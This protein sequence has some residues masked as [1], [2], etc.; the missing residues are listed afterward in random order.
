MLPMDQIFEAIHDAHSEKGHMKAT[1][2]WKHLCKN[3]A[4]ITQKQVTEFIRL[5]P[6]C[7]TDNPVIKPVKGARNPITSEKFRDRCQID[8]IDMR[9]CCKRGIH[10]VVMRWIISVKDHLTGLSAFGA[11]PFQ[12]PKF[13]VHFLSGLFGLIGFPMIF[14]TDNGT[15]FVSKLV[16]RMLK[17]RSPSTTTVTG[18]PRRPQDQG[19]IENMNKLAKRVLGN[20]DQE[21]R[22]AGRGPNWTN[23]LGWL[24]SVVNSHEQ[25]GLHNV[26]SYEA[27]FGLPY[28][29]TATAPCSQTEL[30]KCETIQQRLNLV[31]DPHFKSVVEKHYEIA[32]SDDESLSNLEQDDFWEALK[33]TLMRLNWR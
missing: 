24:M 7:S 11:M 16:I 18:R 26:T 12:K 32:V 9:K 20:F 22:L 10:G 29:G 30:R 23:N 6:I 15:E 14:H 33:M 17:E 19:S 8:L 25:K 27:V 1:P 4:N 13:V 28:S 21:D 2:T 5:C 31:D 3:Y